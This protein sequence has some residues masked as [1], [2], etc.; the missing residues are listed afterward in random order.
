M[1]HRIKDEPDA[2]AATRPYSI[3][4]ITVS[5]TPLGVYYVH[6]ARR[7]A[8]HSH[9]DGVY[10]INAA[11]SDIYWACITIHQPAH[12]ARLTA[13]KLYN[14]ATGGGLNSQFVQI[15]PNNES[16]HGGITQSKARSDMPLVSLTSSHQWGQSKCAI[17]EATRHKHPS[18]N[19]SVCDIRGGHIVGGETMLVNQQCN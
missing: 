10:S 18:S 3:T 13:W 15:F 11:S 7:Y 1:T 8:Y 14:I 9:H 12:G 16:L 5:T 2:I 4:A 19:T 17:N 6:T